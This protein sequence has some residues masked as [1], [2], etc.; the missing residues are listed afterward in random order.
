MPRATQMINGT[1]YVYE[2][3]SVWNKEKKRSEQKREYIGKMVDGKFVP[4]KVYCLK[5]ELAQERQRGRSRKGRKSNEAC[6]R[7]GDKDLQQQ[8]CEEKMLGES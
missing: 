2:Y 7:E 1:E 6:E 3:I 8:G 5:M 4:N